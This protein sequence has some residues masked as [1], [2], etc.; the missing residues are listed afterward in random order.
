MISIEQTFNRDGSLYLV[1][2][3]KNAV[4]TSMERIVGSTL[5]F[6]AKAIFS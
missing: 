4:F 5:K 6:S 2:N 1:C 3:D